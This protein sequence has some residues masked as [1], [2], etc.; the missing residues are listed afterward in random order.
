MIVNHADEFLNLYFTTPLI[1]TCIQEDDPIYQRSDFNNFARLDTFDSDLWNNNDHFSQAEITAALAEEMKKIEIKVV[2]EPLSTEEREKLEKEHADKQVANQVA[3]QVAKELEKEAPKTKEETTALWNRFLRAI[4]LKNTEDVAKELHTILEIWRDPTAIVKEMSW[5]RIFEQ[6]ILTNHAELSKQKDTILNFLQTNQS[7]KDTLWATVCSHWGVAERA[8]TEGVP[9]FDTSL[10]PNL[11]KTVVYYLHGVDPAGF[12][13]MEWINSLFPN[14]IQWRECKEVQE[15]MDVNVMKRQVP[16]LLYLNPHGKDMSQSLKVILDIYQ[17]VGKKLMI[18]HMSD[19]FARNDISMYDHPA[20]QAVYRNYW[21]PGLGN[22]VRVFPLGP[23]KGRS[24]HGLPASP[25]FA[26]R[27]NLW[28]FAGSMDRPTRSTALDALR[29]VKPHREQTMEKWGDR[30]A[31][32]S[33]AYCEMLRNTQFVPCM[34]G[35]AAL[36]SFRMYEALEHGAIPFY[37]PSESQNCA[38]EIQAMYGSSPILSIPS[39]KEASS[40][41]PTLASNPSVMEE[42]RQK[43][44]TWWRS[45]KDALRAKIVAD[46]RPTC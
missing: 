44:Q 21:R 32:E 33:E 3:N 16:I 31:L 45:Q 27:A 8:N 28:S 40:V 4:A 24:A 20:V 23:A 35:S 30:L 13:E 39:W 38:D 9:Y 18:L 26:E 29:E 34:K 12:L 5:F 42:H 36:E 25:T 15:L 43:L 22:K 19:E 37:I 1:A 6:L 10:I 17:S 14:G 7:W 46:V 2:K 11:Q 41:L